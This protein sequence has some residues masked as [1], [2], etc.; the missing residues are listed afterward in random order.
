MSV[1]SGPVRSRSAVQ[2]P[3]AY[4]QPGQSAP[5]ARGRAAIHRRRAG[6]L[7]EASGN[8]RNRLFRAIPCYSAGTNHAPAYSGRAEP[9]PK[10]LGTDW[11]RCMLQGTR[12]FRFGY[13]RSDS[14]MLD[15]LDMLQNAPKCSM[16]VDNMLACAC[17]LA[18][19]LHALACV[20]MRLHV[21]ACLY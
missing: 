17:M 6:E 2:G 18:K 21:L 13:S 14:L 16:N 4:V 3:A 12:L 9:K 8:S 15:W 20:Y 7:L 10:P 11:R 1:R 5:V 19:R